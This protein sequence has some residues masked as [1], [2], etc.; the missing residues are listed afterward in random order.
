[1]MNCDV[2]SPT[3][4]FENLGRGNL[5]NTKNKHNPQSPELAKPT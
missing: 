4:G 1:M 2:W 5:E 3:P